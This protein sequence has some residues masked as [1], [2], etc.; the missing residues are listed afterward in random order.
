MPTGVGLS[1]RR[2]DGWLQR[3]DIFVF[4]T[5]CVREQKT[6]LETDLV[7]AL[8]SALG[9]WDPEL[10]ARLAEHEISELLLPTGL[11]REFAAERCWS[12]STSPLDDV[13]WSQG[14]WQNYLG[15]QAPHTCFAE[16]LSGSRHI[17]HLIWRAEIGVLMPYIEE[18]RQQLI[19]RYRSHFKLPHWTNFGVIE[20]VYDLEIRHV[21]LLLGRSG[22]ISRH[23]AKFV[24]QLK[25]ARNALAHLEPV[26]PDLLLDLCRN[27]REGRY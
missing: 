24:S 16:F 22:V 26:D 23:H 6:G 1:T 18:K 19:E 13:S 25:E 14:L 7:T 27:A 10:C 15:S 21:E 11:L 2:W 17:D 3:H 4:S 9:G 5:T 20:D 8:V 12:F